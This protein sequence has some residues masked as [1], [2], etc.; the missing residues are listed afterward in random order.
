MGFE[1]TSLC[2]REDCLPGQ[3][4]F[5]LVGQRLG[6]T[7]SIGLKVAAS[8]LFRNDLQV[9]SQASEGLGSSFSTD[10]ISDRQNDCPRFMLSLS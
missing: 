1:K 4:N 3:A 8:R 2:G 10:P 5:V 6:G 9:F 7:Q